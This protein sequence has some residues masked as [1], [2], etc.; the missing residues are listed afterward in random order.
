MLPTIN[1]KFKTLKLSNLAN[2]FWG[3]KTAKSA[4]SYYTYSNNGAL[5]NFKFLDGCFVI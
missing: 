3:E 4:E 5:T 2:E 1:K